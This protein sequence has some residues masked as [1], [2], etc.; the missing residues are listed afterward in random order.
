MAHLP[1][2]DVYRWTDALRFAMARQVL[3]EAGIPCVEH[4]RLLDAVQDPFMI[5]VP[6]PVVLRVRTDQAAEAREL[7]RDTVGEGVI[8]NVA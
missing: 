7:L 2:S 5:F 1:L 3:E 4:G 6:K 8:E